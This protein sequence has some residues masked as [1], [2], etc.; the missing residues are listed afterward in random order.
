[1]LAAALLVALAPQPRRHWSPQ[2]SQQTSTVCQQHEAFRRPQ[3][4]Y[5]LQQPLSRAA[6]VCQQQQKEVMVSA[7]LDDDKVTKLFAWIS[8]AFDGD[9]RYGNLM[10][11]FAC[12]FGSHEPGSQY[13]ALVKHAL[14]RRFV[15]PL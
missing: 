2:R 13:A 5:H 9:A 6:V 15:A 7:S 12:I 4:P 3:P 14:K 8:R 11:A 10:L 1:M